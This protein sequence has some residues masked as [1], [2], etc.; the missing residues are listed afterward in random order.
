MNLMDGSKKIFAVA[1][2]A[3]AKEGN[4]TER[5]ANAPLS[6]VATRVVQVDAALRG[7]LASLREMRWI[8]S[9]CAVDLSPEEISFKNERLCE[10][11]GE[12]SRLSALVSGTEFV[13]FS[14]SG[15]NGAVR[16]GELDAAIE[17]MSGMC[18]D[19]RKSGG[20][21]LSEWMREVLGG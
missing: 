14:R 4:F 20:E 1:A 3:R 10:L 6:G 13:M 7:I 11:R 16:L 9:D 8:C 19:G 17:R 5:R 2:Y 21:R 18:G 12:I 15:A